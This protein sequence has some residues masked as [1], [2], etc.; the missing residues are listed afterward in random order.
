MTFE[1]WLATCETVL[2][3]QTST[4]L[5]QAQVGEHR[6]AYTGKGLRL[7]RHE[8]YRPGDERRFIDWKASR[9]DRTLL[10]QRFETEK[11]L[12]VLVLCDVSTS[13]LFGQSVPKYRVALDCAGVLGL[14]TLRQGDAFGLLAFATAPVAYFPPRQQREPVLRALEYLWTY[15]PATVDTTTTQLLPAVQYLPTHRPLLVCVLSDLCTTDWQ[16]ALEIISA[17]HDTIAVLIADAAELSLP[18]IGCIVV[19]DLESGQLM[20]IDTAST[21]YRRAFREH[22]LAERAAREQSLRRTCGTQYVVATAATDYRSDLLRLF[23]ARTA[24]SWI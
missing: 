22:M 18:A 4:R 5:R 10:L 3:L 13:M 20:E 15:D 19:R 12:Q 2:T 14:A 9:K 21:T 16:A 24:R 8:E 7:R 17:S 1:A 23:L 6:S 11:Q